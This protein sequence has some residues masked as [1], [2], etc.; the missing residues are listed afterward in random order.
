MGVCSQVFWRHRG[1][2]LGC[3]VSSLIPYPHTVTLFQVLLN[4]HLSYCLKCIFDHVRATGEHTPVASRLS[5]ASCCRKLSI[6]GPQ[7]SLEEYPVPHTAGQSQQTVE[8][9]QCSWLHPPAHL[10]VLLHAAWTI[11][12][13]LP[14]KLLVLPLT[15]TWHPAEGAF[16]N[17]PVFLFFFFWTLPAVRSTWLRASLQFK[18]LLFLLVVLIVTTFLSWVETVVLFFQRAKV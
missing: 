14:R 1:S 18:F 5:S 2:F 12:H 13:C 9:T 7:R 3:R 17:L 11:V 6:T 10:S 4:S 8:R 16:P 15:L